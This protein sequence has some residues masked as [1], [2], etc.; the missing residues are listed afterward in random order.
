MTS[1]PYPSCI[2]DFLVAWLFGTA[3]T[4]TGP[5]EICTKCRRMYLKCYSFNSW[6]DVG[7]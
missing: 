3:I 7:M 2:S 6:S 4:A 1:S 5:W